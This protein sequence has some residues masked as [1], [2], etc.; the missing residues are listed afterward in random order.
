M[1]L[2]IKGRQQEYYKN[3]SNKFVQLLYETEN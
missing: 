1:K 3:L 2:K